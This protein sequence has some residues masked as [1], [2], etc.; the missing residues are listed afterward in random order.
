MAPGLGRIIVQLLPV[1]RARS[2]APTIIALEA[3]M[4]LN[5]TLRAKAHAALQRSAVQSR[6]PSH[7][8]TKVPGA[9]LVKE[10][11]VLLTVLI[12]FVLLPITGQAVRNAVLLQPT[13]GKQLEAVVLKQVPV[14]RLVITTLGPGPMVV[15][16]MP[17]VLPPPTARRVRNA[18]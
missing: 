13:P 16:L 5:L 9:E 17:I 15:F 7:V 11:H 6:V 2:L 4:S 14:P 18:V 1:P 12:V 10:T 8:L 3:P